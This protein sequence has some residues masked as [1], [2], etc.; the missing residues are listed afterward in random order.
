MLKYTT[1]P[2][3]V[4]IS[5]CS[6]NT[7][8]I[9]CTVCSKHT[10]DLL[11]LHIV[12]LQVSKLEV[13]LCLMSNNCVVSPACSSNPILQML[14]LYLCYTPKGSKT[15]ICMLLNE[16]PQHTV[17]IPI[18][19]SNGTLGKLISEMLASSEPLWLFKLCLWQARGFTKLFYFG[20]ITHLILLPMFCLFLCASAVFITPRGKNELRKHL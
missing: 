9:Q 5:Q 7:C 10:V 8:S 16:N 17:C 3:T 11:S 2:F 20:S 14:M 12:M 1:T 19:C 13:L 4:W 15:F 6:T 18:T